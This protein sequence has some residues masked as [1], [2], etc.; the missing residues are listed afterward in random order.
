MCQS[1][2]AFFHSTVV[3][4]TSHNSHC[5]QQLVIL[6]RNERYSVA[7]FVTFIFS[8]LYNFWIKRPKNLKPRPK[9][10]AIFWHYEA[11]RWQCLFNVLNLPTPFQYEVAQFV[12]KQ[13]NNKF[14]LIF[15]DYFRKWNS[16][17]LTRFTINENFQYLYL[18]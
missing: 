1:Y 2:V 12:H 3:I 10:F 15:S 18:N 4:V 16:T 17:H 5:R 11:I 13:S 8:E 14:P 6:I 9:I 7:R